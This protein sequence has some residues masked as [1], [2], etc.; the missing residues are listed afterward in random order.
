MK[1]KQ[2]I[3][4]CSL[5]LA[6]LIN[7][8]D[9]KTT[10][11]PKGYSIQTIET[12]KDVR[13]HAT[14]LDTNKQGHVYVAT[15]FGDV[16]A[17][18]NDTW[19]KFADGLH[20]PTGLM[21]EDDG[22]ILVGQKPELTRLVDLNKDGVADDYIRI[23]DG[24]EFHDNYH[25]F[26]F[27]PVKDK[28]GN[29]YGTLNLGHGVPDALALG[30]MDSGGGYRGWAYKVS[31]NGKFTPF[32]SGLRSPAGLGI[33][34]ENELFFTDNQGDWVETSKLHLL[35]EGKF[36]GHPVPLR[37]DPNFGLNKVRKNKSNFKL[38]DDMRE[39]PVVWIPHIEVANSPGNPEWDVTKG[40]FGPFE[41]QIFIGDQTQS[42]VFRV[43]LDKVNG[44][45]QG[46]VINFIDGFQSGNI[47]LDFDTQ[48]QLWVGQTARGW[49][50]KGNKPFGLQKVVWN[51]E[52]P[53]ELLDMKLTK[54][55]FKLSFTEALNDKTVLA[56]HFKA[57]EYNYNYTN[58]Y[59]SDK[60]NIKDLKVKNV[61]LSKDKKSA[62]IELDL[63]AD[64]VV[65]VDF[66]NLQNSNQDKPSV[67]KVYYTLNQL[68]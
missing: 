6:G 44:K 63:T 25:E 32:A 12:P 10:Y 47:R 40:K 26:N 51:G 53:F 52:M 48:G 14:G 38:F 67:T 4:T 1:F 42:N 34:P 61:T 11:I 31:N 5:M 41:N 66:S 17:Y 33:S 50:A 3:L 46:A 28:A 58:R 49:G 2:S 37:D 7:V 54:K 59:G 60:H 15:R 43:M 22:S 30:A 65:V 29:Y 55:G 16:W 19:S 27:A 9:A 20:E 56:K 18:K 35:E 64:K 45:Y 24:W 21:C 62:E 36:Y 68:L 13:F 39:K 57:H 8:A 23:A